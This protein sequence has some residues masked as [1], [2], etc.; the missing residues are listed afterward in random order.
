MSQPEY[1]GGRGAS[2]A[3]TCDAHASHRL[4]RVARLSAAHKGAT[5]RTGRLFSWL[6]DPASSP[7]VASISELSACSGACHVTMAAARGSSTR[8]AGSCVRVCAPL[9]AARGTQQGTRCE[10]VRSST[11]QS[12]LP[13]LADQ[14]RLTR[15]APPC[16]TTPGHRSLRLLSQARLEIP[17]GGEER[18]TG[19]PARV[20]PLVLRLSCSSCPGFRPSY[21][22]R[23][24]RAATEPGPAKQ[25]LSASEPPGLHRLSHQPL[26]GEPHQWRSPCRGC[27]ARAAC[28]CSSQQHQ[29]QPTLIAHRSSGSCSLRRLS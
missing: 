28:C 3:L 16:R 20:R 4:L 27:Q 2:A 6:T 26:Q 21:G 24:P 19:R 7:S 29:D 9:C 25:G 11:S 10:I 23:A 12:P 15:S 5:R 13:S 17:S 8:H 22:S 14:P 1:R 18:P